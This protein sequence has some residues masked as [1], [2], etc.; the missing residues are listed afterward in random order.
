MNAPSSAWTRTN[1]S[2]SSQR[3]T[4]AAWTVWSIT[5]PPPARRLSPNHDPGYWPGFVARM[6]ATNPGQ[7]PG[8]W[9]GDK[10]LAGGGAVMDHT[11]HAADVIRWLLSD[12]FVRVQAE[13]GAF[14]Y[15][16]EVEDC[17]ILTCDLAGGAFASIDCSWS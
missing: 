2:L 10:R 13:L 12:E 16:L 7:Y 1:S 17:G 15:G 8:S 5:A 6:R 4:S 9:F 3:I 11:V 14:I